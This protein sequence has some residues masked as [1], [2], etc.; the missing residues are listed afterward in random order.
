M[1]AAIFMCG[2][3]DSGCLTEYNVA[4]SKYFVATMTILRKSFRPG[5]RNS[6]ELWLCGYYVSRAC[7]WATIKGW[8]RKRFIWVLCV[9]HAHWM[10]KGTVSGEFKGIYSNCIVGILN[11]YFGIRGFAQNQLLLYAEMTK[12]AFILTA[13]FYFLVHILFTKM[14]QNFQR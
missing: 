9:Q 10:S 12:R 6:T 5:E 2:C 3:G 11:S 1:N 4:D 7:R 14:S 13:F 8:W